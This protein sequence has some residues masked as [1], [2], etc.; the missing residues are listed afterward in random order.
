MRQTI[1]KTK[2][3]HLFFVRELGSGL[4]LV[5]NEYGCQTSVNWSYFVRIMGLK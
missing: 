1:I 3:G 4:A 5:T 2:T